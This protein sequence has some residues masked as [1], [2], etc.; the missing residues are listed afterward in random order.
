VWGSVV[1]YHPQSGY[2]YRYT[3]DAR[4]GERVVVVP[5][6]TSYMEIVPGTYA[7]NTDQLFQIVGTT[8]TLVTSLLPQQFLD[9][10]RFTGYGGYVRAASRTGVLGFSFTPTNPFQRANSLLLYTDTAAWWIS[11]GRN[12]PDV[13]VL[14]AE[15]AGNIYQDALLGGQRFTVF[16][17]LVTT[18]KIWIGTYAYLNTP[19]YYVDVYDWVVLQGGPKLQSLAQSLLQLPYL[20]PKDIRIAGYVAP[21]NYLHIDGLGTLE[22]DTWEYEYTVERGLFTTARVGRRGSEQQQS[23]RI[24][25]TGLSREW[26]E[27]LRLSIGRT[28]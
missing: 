3:K 13:P 6:I 24:A 26:A 16:T 27:R 9:W 19:D 17:P 25:I 20:T 15:Q 1:L 10:D 28:T 22:I 2:A 5:N 14:Y 4:Y 8:R 18:D 23:Q 7:H 12:M 21:A 11:G